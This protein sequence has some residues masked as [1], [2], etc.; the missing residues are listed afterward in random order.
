[1]VLRGIAQGRPNGAV[2]KNLAGGTV[3]LLRPNR[4]RLPAGLAYGCWRVWEF[5]RNSGQDMM[6]QHQDNQQVQLHHCQQPG[7]CP[8]RRTT[9]QKA[10]HDSRSIP[11]TF[12]LQQMRNGC[13]F[14]PMGCNGNPK[15]I[16]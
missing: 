9:L 2:A 7:G 12:P 1:M 15:S 6:V 3:A 11:R 5:Q 4:L 14:H 16:A 13:S 10:Q 8:P